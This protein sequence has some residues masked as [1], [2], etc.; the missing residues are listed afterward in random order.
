MT[1]GKDLALRISLNLSE[2]VVESMEASITASEPMMLHVWSATHVH[3]RALREGGPP[4]RA[5]DRQTRAVLW[6]T[7][8]CSVRAHFLSLSSLMPVVAAAGA[9][10]GASPV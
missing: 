6:W 3:D 7:V 10:A 2:F 5:C 4:E 8:P 9:L 1:K